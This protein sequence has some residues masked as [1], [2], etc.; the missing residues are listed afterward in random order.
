MKET[1][2]T[3]GAL[4]CSALVGLA[5]CG[6]SGS[7]EPSDGGAMEPG[8]SGEN[9]QE[10]TEQDTLPSQATNRRAVSCPE[11][12]AE[13][14]STSQAIDFPVEVTLG[15]WDGVPEEL[16]VMPNGAELCGSVDVLNQGLIVSDLWGA[17]LESR[18]RPIFEN[19]DCAPFECELA[20]NGDLQQVRCSCFSAEH[21]GSLTAP[22]DVAYY[23][24][25]YD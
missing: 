15:T 4:V 14:E 2:L 25:S 3:F 19:L 12:E 22:S 18:Y 9:E 17:E 7:N 10:T 23:L 1:M 6:D 11:L 20:T 24:L 5:A 13:I 21:F 16:K 8:P